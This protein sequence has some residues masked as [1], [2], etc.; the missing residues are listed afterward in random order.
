MESRHK[1]KRRSSILKSRKSLADVDSNA[2]DISM[3]EEDR[4]GLKRRVSFANTYQV[5][6]ISRVAD[7]AEKW[8]DPTSHVDTTNISDASKLSCAVP[9][10]KPSGEPDASSLS[11]L[12]LAP[13]VQQTCPASSSNALNE[14]T[15]SNTDLTMVTSTA[16]SHPQSMISD[17]SDINSASGKEVPFNGDSMISLQQP[18]VVPTYMVKEEINEEEPGFP[19]NYMNEDD[20]DGI[21][22]TF[23]NAP[24]PAFL[25]TTTQGGSNNRAATMPLLSQSSPLKVCESEGYSTLHSSIGLTDSMPNKSLPPL[26]ARHTGA[27]TPVNNSVLSTF[28]LQSSNEDQELNNT[29]FLDETVDLT[30]QIPSTS[31]LLANNDHSFAGPSW[32]QEAKGLNRSLRSGL[33]QSIEN[34]TG[35]YNC[36]NMEITCKITSVIQ[37]HV[38]TP[39]DTCSEKISDSHTAVL[40]SGLTQSRTSVCTDKND[41][42]FTCVITKSGTN[43]AGD[44]LDSDDNPPLLSSNAFSEN[45][46]ATNDSMEFTMT[47]ST[48]PDTHPNAGNE[49]AKFLA[50]DP[51]EGESS[52]VELSP[53]NRVIA[54]DTLYVSS[55]KSRD[56]TVDN[57]EKSDTD[58]MGSSGN[59]AD[60]EVSTHFRKL[61]KA[62]NSMGLYKRNI[63]QSSQNFGRTLDTSHFNQNNDNESFNLSASASS[64][65][66]FYH[67]PKEHELVSL[68]SPEKYTDRMLSSSMVAEDDMNDLVAS[69]EILTEECYD[70][71]QECSSHSILESKNEENMFKFSPLETCEDKKCE[72][73]ENSP[74]YGSTSKVEKRSIS[75]LNKDNQDE[76][77]D[78][79]ISKKL[80]LDISDN[81]ASV[82]ECGTSEELE[83]TTKPRESES[84]SQEISSTQD[85]LFMLTSMTELQK[86]LPDSIG[87]Q[88]FLQNYTDIRLGS[89]IKRD[90][91]HQSLVPHKKPETLDELATAVFVHARSI[92]IYTQFLNSMQQKMESLSK[93][94]E[95]MEQQIQANNTEVMRSIRFGS[96]EESE[97]LTTEVESLASRCKQL[98]KAEWKRDKGKLNKALANIKE[99]TYTNHL[100]PIVNQI[101]QYGKIEDLMRTAVEDL[102]AANSIAEQE[103]QI[104]H[105]RGEL[106]TAE[107][108]ACFQKQEKEINDLMQKIKTA[109]QEKADIEKRKKDLKEK[110]DRLWDSIDERVR[111]ESTLGER[112][113]TAKEDIKLH[114][115][116]SQ[117]KLTGKYQHKAE[118]SFLRNSLLVRASHSTSDLNKVERYE[119]LANLAGARLSRRQKTNYRFVISLMMRIVTPTVLLDKGPN[120][121]DVTRAINFVSIHAVKAKRLLKQIDQV[122][123]MYGNVGLMFNENSIVADFDGDQPNFCSFQVKFVFANNDATASF[124]PISF[125][126]HDS[127]SWFGKLD[128]QA[129][130]QALND[131][132]PT[133][134]HYFSELVNA[135]LNIIRNKG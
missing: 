7:I 45:A 117:W 9:T 80:C 118:F 88:D 65:P 34:E 85:A 135:V 69:E 61:S 24:L 52:I 62:R 8:P 101:N 89:Y 41:M 87:I 40:K 38:T 6:E 18:P 54:T 130:D 121:T 23:D 133:S 20:D 13:L 91:R 60:Q 102:E 25:H 44:S 123:S 122:Q 132:P 67:S 108:I 31:S 53:E 95:L 110:L 126:F 76:D 79:D 73:F 50:L 19:L 22:E 32:L 66:P 84:S 15:G 63:I 115:K 47:Q 12:L 97:A 11:S 112:N 14:T 116:L 94:V 90:K 77:L 74:V 104:H 103:L 134:V 29:V 119:I 33:K 2:V 127:P 129:I 106:P 68:Q 48:F 4:K 124:H 70:E 71:E 35:D 26:T 42:E 99:E 17:S 28:M 109:K 58:T 82:E 96:E 78:S 27:Q 30:R 1:K 56:A 93:D 125:H 113:K 100:E 39:S 111:R 81:V 83:P 114:Q 131:V 105:E 98:A 55:Q 10:K 21:T 120:K 57:N 72:L 3:T 59:G 36:E 51:K 64:S 37:Q 5:K 86:D 46:A 107:Q 16:L 49:I 92:P 43:I 128:R 75:E